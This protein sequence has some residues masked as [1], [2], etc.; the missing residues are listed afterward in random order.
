MN[1]IFI[2]KS[3]KIYKED[4]YNLD[5][6]VLNLSYPRRSGYLEKWP[7]PIQLAV[8]PNLCNITLVMSLLLLYPKI[9]GNDVFS[10]NLPSCCHISFP[11]IM[12]FD[13]K[14]IH[15]RIQPHACTHHVVTIVVIVIIA[16]LT[17]CYSIMPYVA[18]IIY[19]DTSMWMLHIFLIYISCA[20]WLPRIL[21][22]S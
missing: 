14:I 2:Y 7:R 21:T 19:Y 6:E 1:K 8:Y 4:D 3:S 18:L 22:A 15:Q 10:W 9:P 20:L 17:L 5:L 13:I 12:G 11:Y 16:M